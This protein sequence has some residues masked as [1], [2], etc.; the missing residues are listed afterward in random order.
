M[1]VPCTHPTLRVVEVNTAR[2]VSSSRRRHKEFCHGVQ[3][4]RPGRYIN[5]KRQKIEEHDDKYSNLVLGTE[6]TPVPSP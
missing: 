2:H 6:Y 5:V 3:E 4:G 1:E